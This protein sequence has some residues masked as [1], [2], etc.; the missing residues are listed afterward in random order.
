MENKN[1][2]N[3]SDIIELIHLAINEDIGT[4]DITSMA[5]FSDSDMSTAE[6]ISKDTGICCGI[7]I[8]RFVYDEIEP[9]IAITAH[10]TDGERLR[11]GDKLLSLKGMTSSILAGERIV[12][13]FMQ[14]MCGIAT[15]SAA[16]TDFIKGTGTAILDTR[17][18][19]PGFRKLDKYA[20]KTGGSSNHRMGL[21]D[22]VMIKDNH[23]KAA[24]GIN[25]AVEKIKKAYG[26]KYLIEIEAS[27]IDEVREAAKC[28]V[29]IIMLDNMT[30]PMMME[31]I[32]IIAGRT[33][34]E[35][36]GNI[37]KESLQAISKLDIDYVSIGALTHTVKAFDLSMKFV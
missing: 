37:D 28:D 8:P 22:M 15:K 36:S 29:D 35:I 26:N 25:Q 12:L 34:I 14:R 17:K 18:T 31:S 3:R 2:I 23:I 1:M 7:D 33:K 4:G 27:A 5:I 30:G 10:V 21:Y 6:I 24:G 19:L 11:P 20:V 9:A 16:F 13:N 32:E